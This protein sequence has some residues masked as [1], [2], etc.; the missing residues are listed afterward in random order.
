MDVKPWAPPRFRKRAESVRAAYRRDGRCGDCGAGIYLDGERPTI[1][2]HHP[3]CPTLRAIVAT[4]QSDICSQC[5]AT[6]ERALGW[7][8]GAGLIVKIAWCPN[9]H[10]RKQEWIDPND[11]TQAE[12]DELGL[13]ESN[14]T[15]G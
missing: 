14:R 13:V 9:G 7:D 1:A 11:A 8:G 10:S 15:G 6:K 2:P 12:R 3:S 4:E 5:G